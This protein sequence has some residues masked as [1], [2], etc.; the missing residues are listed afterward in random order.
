MFIVVQQGRRSACYAAPYGCR[1]TAFAVG[2][3]NNQVIATPGP[4]S[5]AGLVNA[6]GKSVINNTHS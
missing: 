5:F 2:G 6:S 1:C 3:T 4:L